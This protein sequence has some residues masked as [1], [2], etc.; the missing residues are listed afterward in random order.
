MV[1]RASVQGGF[2]RDPEVVVFP[3]LGVPP[4]D[5]HGGHLASHVPVF[6]HFGKFPTPGSAYRFYLSAP[7]RLCARRR[8]ELIKS[9]SL[10]RAQISA[11][12]RGCHLPSSRAAVWLHSSPIRFGRGR[13]TRS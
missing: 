6:L 5:F 3:F 4:G 13:G 1:K 9:L 10:R 2:L 12:R 11:G 8:H 7:R